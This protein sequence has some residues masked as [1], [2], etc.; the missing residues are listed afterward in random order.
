MT[1]CKEKKAALSKEITN[2][3]TKIQAGDTS[4]YNDFAI[5]ILAAIK[6]VVS[7]FYKDPN[8]RLEAMNYIATKVIN[9]ITYIDIN[10]PVLNYILYTANNYCIDEY[11]K[12]RRKHGK[13]ITTDNETLD[14]F[15]CR[16]AADNLL[17]EDYMD[18]YLVATKGNSEHANIVY[19]LE[20]T[21]KSPEE[22]SY[23]FKLPVETIKDIH[24]DALNSLKVIKRKISSSK[25]LS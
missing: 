3:V 9:K 12:K 2:I 11:R 21:T 22:L 18:L 10:K 6:P 13:V 8:D 20:Q 25:A 5:M 24:K 16:H 7:R 1:T 15:P 17:Y 14:L 23:L 19:N 4:L